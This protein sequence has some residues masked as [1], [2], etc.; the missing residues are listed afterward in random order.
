[1]IHILWPPSMKSRI[2]GPDNTA[3][4]SFHAEIISNCPCKFL[5]LV[6]KVS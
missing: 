3:C 5:E 6:D 1:M 4:I 2:M